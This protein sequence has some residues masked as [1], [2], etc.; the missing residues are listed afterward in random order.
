VTAALRQR[1]LYQT[2]DAFGSLVVAQE[3]QERFLTFGNSIH[4]SS[5]NLAQPE[6]PVF[7][8]LRKMFLSFALVPAPKHIL[9]LGLGAGGLARA[10]HHHFPQVTITALELRESLIDIA[11]AYFDLP[12]LI[13]VHCQDAQD[14]FSQKHPPL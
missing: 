7:D 8:Y 2:Q 5:L 10:I 12:S 11:R 13:E 14:F 1:I 4:Q 6:Q 3:S 9:L